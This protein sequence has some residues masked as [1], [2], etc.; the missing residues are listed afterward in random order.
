MAHKS[1]PGYEIHLCHLAQLLGL[2][3]AKREWLQVATAVA[4]T[5]IH[6]LRGQSGPQKFINFEP[7]KLSDP[8][9]ATC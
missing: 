3:T 6:F 2:Y 9:L 1:P 5:R 7:R 8:G 4:T